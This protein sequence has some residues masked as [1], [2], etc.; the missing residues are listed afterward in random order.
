MKKL[1]V[2]FVLISFSSNVGMAQNNVNFDLNNN[3]GKIQ[4]SGKNHS[5]RAGKD[6][7]NGSL[8]IPVEGRD[9]IRINSSG[10]G[11]NKRLTIRSKYGTIRF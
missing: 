10:S 1:L 8:S 7:L 5:I 11:K 4:L 3:K 9:K 6:G 2:F